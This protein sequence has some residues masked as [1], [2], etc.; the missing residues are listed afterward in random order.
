MR[1]EKSLTVIIGGTGKTGRRV[2]QRLIA[3]GQPIRITSRAGSPPF[4]WSDR[5]TWPAVVRG[6]EA[7]YLAYYPDITVPSAAVDI[8]A[9]A[10]LAVASGVQR[11]VLLSGRGEQGALRSERALRDSGAAF[12]ILRAAFFAQNF[13]EGLLLE[14]V[15]AGA[16]AFPAGNVPEPFVDADDIADVAV[17]ALTDVAH[18]GKTYE[19]TGPR[20]LT[21]ADVAAEIARAADHEVRYLPTAPADYTRMLTAFMPVDDA[22]VY[23]ELFVSLFDGHNAQLC[24]GVQSVL[25][26]PP[27]DF[28]DFAQAAARAGAWAITASQTAAGRT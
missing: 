3:R 22:K 26:R 19:L 1:D 9:L 11:I 23:T 6:A 27:R 28:R 25:G 16:L 12:T 20:L 24:D 14:P 10:R 18:S 13:S 4:E 17:A 8:A 2:A 15:L 21:F 7:M 5:S